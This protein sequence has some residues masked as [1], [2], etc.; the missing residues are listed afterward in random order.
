MDIILLDWVLPAT[1]GL[2]FMRQVRT[3]KGSRNPFVPILM[4]TADSTQGQVT[5]ARNSG[6]NEFLTNPLSPKALYSRL[7][8]TIDHPRPFVPKIILALA[9]DDASLLIAERSSGG[10]APR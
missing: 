6:A 1:S 10:E 9:V 2:E 4:I 7:S 5:E 8:A 3:S